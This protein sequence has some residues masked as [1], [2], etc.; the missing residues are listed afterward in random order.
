[1]ILNTVDF[2]SSEACTAE[3]KIIN[4]LTNAWLLISPFFLVVLSLG[5]AFCLKDVMN[6]VSVVY[7]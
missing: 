6:S 1:V 3:D 2:L 7:Y 4:I 5:A